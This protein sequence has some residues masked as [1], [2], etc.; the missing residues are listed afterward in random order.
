MSFIIL[1]LYESCSVSILIVM[2]V[3]I[4]NSTFS[5]LINFL[6]LCAQRDH[7]WYNDL[8]ILYAVFVFWSQCWNSL[9][10]RYTQ[11]NVLLIQQ[12]IFLGV[13]VSVY[14]IVQLKCQLP[15]RNVTILSIRV[16]IIIKSNFSLVFH[17]N[18]VR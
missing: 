1:I 13:A 8:F 11:K 10:Q 16:F 12:N 6:T 5:K 18:Y 2:C 4:R 15:L 17:K 3:A 14:T 9:P 7:V